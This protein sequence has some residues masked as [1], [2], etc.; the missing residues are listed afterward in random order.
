MKVMTLHLKNQREK[1]WGFGVNFND[2]WFYWKVCKVANNSQADDFGLTP[3]WNILQVNELKMGPK[4]H[5]QIEN[6]L[7]SGEACSIKLGK[8]QVLF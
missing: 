7:R 2:A 6:I 4:T 8:L 1:A 5:V 3:G